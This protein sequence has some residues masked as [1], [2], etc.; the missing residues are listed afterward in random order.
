MIQ[1]PIK[2][3]FSGSDAIGANFVRTRVR[4][5]VLDG[6]GHVTGHT[7]EW[8]TD[9]TVSFTVRHD[10]GS[11]LEIW[12]H[13]REDA[14]LNFSWINAAFRDEAWTAFMDKYGYQEIP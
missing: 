10:D 13:V 7:V 8:R 14:P 12:E 3:G 9:C 5:P 11:E 6:D 4:V 2:S 1:K